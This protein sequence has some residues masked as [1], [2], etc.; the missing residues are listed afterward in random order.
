MNIKFLRASSLTCILGIALAACDA[1]TD[2]IGANANNGSGQSV[3]QLMDA[4]FGGEGGW[5]SQDRARH[6][7]PEELWFYSGIAGQTSHEALDAFANEKGFPTSRTVKTA[8]MALDGKAIPEDLK[9]KAQCLTSAS[10][11]QLR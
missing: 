4:Q 9:H 1:P 7:C 5:S 3:G 10:I 6:K 8:H 11:A 2:E